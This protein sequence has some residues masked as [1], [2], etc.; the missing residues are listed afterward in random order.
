MQ[1]AMRG[2]SVLLAQVGSTVAI[3][4][5][6]CAVFPPRLVA[7]Q[8]CITVSLAASEVW[9]F[10]VNGL[11]DSLGIQVRQLSGEA[12]TLDIEYFSSSTWSNLG[13]M[14]FSYDV[15]TF[16]YEDVRIKN[17]ADV[18][19][20]EYCLPAVPTST[21]TNTVTPSATSTVTASPTPTELVIVTSTPIPP[22]ATPIPDYAAQT[23]DIAAISLSFQIVAGGLLLVVLVT[24]ALRY[25]V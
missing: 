12:D 15:F 9:V 5:F 6:L 10:S 18:A 22:T 2:Q 13:V 1:V 7:A 24:I 8:S 14:G 23:R 16:S 17:N 21:P 11:T 3:C 4:I 20:F 19:S 25:K